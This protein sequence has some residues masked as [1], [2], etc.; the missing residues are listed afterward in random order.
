MGEMIFILVLRVLKKARW[1]NWDE[2]LADLRDLSD[3]LVWF[4]G[5][6]FF[7]LDVQF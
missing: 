5:C 1:V 2:N 3:D 4:E 6:A 7:Q